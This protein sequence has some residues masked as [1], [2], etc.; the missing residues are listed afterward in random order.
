MANGF[1]EKDTFLNADQ[2]TRD[3]LLWDMFSAIYHGQGVCQKEVFGRLKILENSK[4][5]NAV[6]NTSVSGV[7]GFFG[8]FI[9]ILTKPFMGGPG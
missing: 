9:A 1:V 6:V 2:E 8:G 7:A 5:K 4:M 3:A